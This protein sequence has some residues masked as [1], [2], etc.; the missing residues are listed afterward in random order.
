LPRTLPLRDTDPM[1]VY[2][3]PFHSSPPKDVGS[4]GSSYGPLNRAIQ[5]RRWPYDNGDDPAFFSRKH[6][7]GNL[8]WGVCRQNVRNPIAIGDVV[9]FFSFAKTA[10]LTEYRPCAVATVQE[11]VRQ[12][13]LWEGAEWSEYR[14]YLN[15]LIRPNGK[16]WHHHEPGANKSEWH[17]DWLWRVA[18][19]RGLRTSAFQQ[20]QKDNKFL[21]SSVVGG[22][23]LR[24]ASNYVIFSADPKLTF[25]FR[26]T[27]PVVAQCEGSGC[28]ETW[29]PDSFSR[30]VKVLT[31]AIAMAHGARG[32]LRTTNAQ[33]AHPH[34][35]WQMDNPNG[36]RWRKELIALLRT[37]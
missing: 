1:R 5:R 15:L 35:K 12:T 6:F 32:T 31:V 2:L 7:G 23:P 16:A 18:D 25:I 33:R 28:T 17:G 26:K 8:T 36:E 14:R 20:I 13:D 3:S 10:N 19:H 34:V 22:R 30:R 29:R 9:V 21:W 37:I 4:C 24:I 27:P 11:K